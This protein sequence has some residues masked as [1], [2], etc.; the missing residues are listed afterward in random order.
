MTSRLTQSCIRWMLLALTLLLMASTPITLAQTSPSAV[1]VFS[2]WVRL[3]LRGFSQQEIESVLRNMDDKTLNEVKNRL[4]RT[5]LANP[6]LKKV[7]KQI[8]LSRD[9][10]DLAT[11]ISSIQTEIRFAG[12]Q[13]DELLKL[14]IKDRYGIRLDL[15]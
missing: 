1:S 11:V 14:R 3:S 10:D 9:S 5:V 15:F 2:I 7:G 4:R 6:Q 8:R 13:N 12:M